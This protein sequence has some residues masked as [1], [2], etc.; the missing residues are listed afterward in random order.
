MFL[1]AQHKI[2][3]YINQHPEA[4]VPLMLWH[5]NYATR[6]KFLSD[7]IP[8]SSSNA[9][10]TASADGYEI[11]TQINFAVKAELITWV[12]TKA[13]NEERKEKQK[14][15]MLKY[16][17]DRGV[18]VESSIETF[19]SIIGGDKSVK[20]DKPSL[21]INSELKEKLASLDMNPA[22]VVYFKTKDEYEAGLKSATNLF[23]SRPNSTDFSNLCTLL[24]AIDEYEKKGFN[25]PKVENYEY[26]KIRMDLLQMTY[27]DFRDIIPQ[28][29]DFQL[30]FTGELNF[31]EAILKR[32]YT[33]LALRF[34]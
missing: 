8:L 14:N 26:V 4:R 32:L 30:Y 5:N 17:H 19:T 13:E 18:A 22:D 25:W 28:E 9:K 2:L 16:Y 1:I 31:N 12:G 3:A 7:S 24:P 15:K 23:K 27:P 29:S 6:P 21:T 33:R 10:G 20:I 11:E 34:L